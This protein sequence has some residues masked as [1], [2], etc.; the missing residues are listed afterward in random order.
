MSQI[1]C[2]TLAQHQGKDIMMFRINDYS[3]SYVEILNYGATLVSAVVPDHKGSLG[4][5]ILNY[6]DMKDYFTDTCYLGSTIGRFANRIGKAQFTLNGKTF[7]LDKN[8][9]ENCN[10]GGYSGFHQKVFDAEI[11]GDELVLTTHSPDGENGFPGNMKVMIYFTFRNNELTI[12]YTALSDCET[13]FNPTCH[14]YFN[15]SEQKKSV[16]QHELQISATEYLETNNDFLPTGKILPI[17]NTAFDFSQYHTI[18]QMAAQKHDLLKGFN[19]YFPVPD[20]G[21]LRRLAT[22]KEPMSGRMINVC[23]TMPGILLYTGDYLHG[24]HQPFEGLCLEVQFHPDTPNHAHF[25]R[26]TLMPGKTGEHI[27]LFQFNSTKPG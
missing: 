18:G 13:L 21:R 23:S 7:H 9:G 6:P 14:A 4:N 15:L 8:D 19:T 27:I 1:T 24:Q 16:F 10:H 3:G 25:P 2:K 12:R 17:A 22:L 5:V 20:N 26:Y 11:R